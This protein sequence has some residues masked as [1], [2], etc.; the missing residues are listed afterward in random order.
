MPSERI[1]IVDRERRM[2]REATTLVDR[3]AHRAG[4]HAGRG[5]L[6]VD[7]PADVLGVGLAAVGPPGVMAGLAVQPPEHVDEADL[8][9]DMRQPR[10]LLRREAGVLLVRAPVGEID[11]LVRDVPDA[12][13]DDFLLAAAKQLQVPRKMLEET[14]LR[15]LAVR[16]G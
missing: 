5:N 1:V 6:I 2:V 11:L 13:Q 12:A 10:A 4:G 8:I 9:E 15:G 3:L 7:S 14:Q 16:A